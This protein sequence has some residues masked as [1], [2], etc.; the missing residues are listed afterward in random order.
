MLS[1]QTKIKCTKNS[2]IEKMNLHKIEKKK[3]DNNNAFIITTTC[4]RRMGLS[5]R[6]VKWK[7]RTEKENLKPFSVQFLL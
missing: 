1:N 4:T 3:N 7:K 2:M 5:K 6:H